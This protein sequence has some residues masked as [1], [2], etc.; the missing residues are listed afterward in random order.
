[1][2]KTLNL[3]ADGTSEEVQIEGRINVAAFGDFGSGSLAVELS[4]DGG[5]SWFAA[6]GEG[7]TSI[8]FTN[9][10]SVLIEVGEASVRFNLS[11]ATSPSL[12]IY[13]SGVNRASKF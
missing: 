11:G 12:T 13:L 9:G 3:T 7:G 8:S 2:G 4:Y 5:V 6:T 1:M 10:D